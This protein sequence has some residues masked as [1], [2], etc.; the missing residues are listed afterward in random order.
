MKGWYRMEVDDEQ[1]VD[2][3]EDPFEGK[4]IFLFLAKLMEILMFFTTYFTPLIDSFVNNNGSTID[5]TSKFGNLI[6]VIPSI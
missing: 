4:P 6:F 3:T 5:V 2:Y 1:L